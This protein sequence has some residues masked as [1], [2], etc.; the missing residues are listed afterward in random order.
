MPPSCPLPSAAPFP[1]IGVKAILLL[2]AD[3]RSFSPTVTLRI[4]F[5]L[6]RSVNNNPFTLNILEQTLLLVVGDTGTHGLT[7]R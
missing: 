5:T 7:P 1:D 3:A 2:Q 6:P 4:S